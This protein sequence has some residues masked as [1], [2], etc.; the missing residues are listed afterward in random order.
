MRSLAIA[1]AIVCLLCARAQ[2]AEKTFPYVGYIEADSA[3]VRGGPGA[4]FYV[5]D[6][7]DRGSKVEVYRQDPGGWLAVR[8]PAGSFGWV[9]ADELRMTNNE[10]IAEATGDDVAAWIG[11]RIGDVREL[12]WQVRLEQGELVEVLGVKRFATTSDGSAETYY[13][14]SPPAGEFRWVRARD[15][16]R[17]P[18]EEVADLLTDAADEY[19]RDNQIRRAE[20]QQPA[21]SQTGRSSESGDGFVARG[22]SASAPKRIASASPNNSPTGIRESNNSAAAVRPS[23]NSPATAGADD[24]DTQLRKIDIEL[25]LMVA[26]EP[27]SWQLTT[28]RKRTEA[29][30]EAGSTATERG[31]AR[32]LLDKVRDFENLQLRSD[33]AVSSDR[34]AEDVSPRARNANRGNTDT[35]AASTDTASRDAATT[36][37]MRIGPRDTGPDET[38]DPNYDGSGWLMPVHSQNRTAPLYALLNDDGKVLHYISPAPGLNLHRYLRQEVGIRGQRGYIEKLNTPHLTAERVIVLDRHRK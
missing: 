30:V 26:R 23:A 12:R 17:Q 32:L 33:D 21:D 34:L 16:N 4:D 28:L 22:T 38:D 7:L 5:T 9:A 29:L 35:G 15:V 8:P 14:I 20:F 27:D 37:A 10:G 3:E 31:R 13:K 6:R 11:S 18:L 19:I 2:A 25:S 36:G 1:G 24:F